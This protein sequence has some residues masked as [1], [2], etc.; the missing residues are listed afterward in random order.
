MGTLIL[1]QL[2]LDLKCTDGVDIVAKE[3]DAIRILAT[4]GID[5]EDR[6][7]HRKLTWFI[8]VIHLSETKV[9]KRFPD[10]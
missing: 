5:I 7:A 3:V 6:T 8:D 10:I 1:R 2:I 9:T 4:I